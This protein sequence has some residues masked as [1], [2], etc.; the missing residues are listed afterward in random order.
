[1]DSID[2]VK[3]NKLYNLKIPNLEVKNALLEN[4]L[5]QYSKI[6]THGIIDYA[7]KLLDYTLDCN[8]EKIV[9]TLGDYLSPISNNIRGKDERFYHG[10]IFI[11]LYSTK[12]HVHT[13]LS[14]FKGGADLVI[15]DGDTVI[16]IEF[17]QDD[18]KSIEYMIN[19]AMDQIE[20]KEY[21]R[22][23]KNKKIVKG[24]IVF[25]KGEIGCKLISE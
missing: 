10:L 25:K 11:L 13:E 4:L 16:I 1:M 19:E 15:E 6:P 23:Y 14:S 21:V 7:Q 5:R 12:I 22:Q 18:K 2:R 17:K 20:K 8:C 24:A 9:E 3:R